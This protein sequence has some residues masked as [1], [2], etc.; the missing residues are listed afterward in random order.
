[1]VHSDPWK[2]HSPT[3]ACTYLLRHWLLPDLMFSR[4]NP[5]RHIVKRAPKTTRQN[6]KFVNP[7]TAAQPP[8]QHHQQPRQP[9]TAHCGVLWKNGNGPRA[10]NATED[11]ARDLMEI[12]HH[13]FAMQT[14]VQGRA[15][16]LPL[17]DAAA[18]VPNAVHEAEP[19]KQLLEKRKRPRPEA[20]EIIPLKKNRADHLSS[21]ASQPRRAALEA[22]HM[23]RPVSICNAPLPK[24]RGAAAMDCLLTTASPEVWPRANGRQ[25]DVARLK[26]LQ[27]GDCEAHR[28][29]DQE[30]G[31]LRVQLCHRADAAGA[32]PPA[33]AAAGHQQHEADEKVEGN[34][35]TLCEPD[36]GRQSTAGA[37]AGRSVPP[38]APPPLPPIGHAV[39]PCTVPPPAPP[40]P[41]PI[42][43]AVRPCT[44][45]PAVPP[46]AS[47]VPQAHAPALGLSTPHAHCEGPSRGEQRT[48]PLPPPLP[49]PHVTTGHW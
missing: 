36:Q 15:A 14:T 22:L 39:R 13:L 33:P 5:P 10:L 45:P 16:P 35:P 4:T 27:E 30:A 48:P 28:S 41:P 24:A 6:I 29:V 32:A 12:K 7:Q 18:Q 40:P 8:K 38:P 3:Q 26:V 2:T 42:G 23:Q 21:A 31:A 19:R 34:A 20:S 46:V 37:L 47:A 1:M 44:V 49:T 43:H 17:P 11:A 25:E 9:D